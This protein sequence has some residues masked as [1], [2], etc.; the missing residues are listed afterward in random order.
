[1]V[2]SHI[3]SAAQRKRALEESARWSK[4]SSSLLSEL[5]SSQSTSPLWSHQLFLLVPLCSKS[6]RT[7]AATNL[8]SGEELRVPPKK[9]HLWAEALISLTGSK[10]AS[11]ICHP[12]SF[13]SCRNDLSSSQTGEKQEKADPTE[14][15]PADLNGLHTIPI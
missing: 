9:G 6:R 11:S 3:F 7:S 15:I 1:M 10:E 12:G 5:V 2:H 8:S 13:A 4:A 14:H